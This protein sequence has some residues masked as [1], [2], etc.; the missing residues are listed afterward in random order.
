MKVSQKTILGVD[1]DTATATEETNAIIYKLQETARANVAQLGRDKNSFPL[2]PSSALKSDLDL[3][4]ALLNWEAPGTIPTN[5]I[6]G[7]AC[8]LLALGHVIEKHLV[9]HLEA[10]YKIPYKAQKITYGTI[11][12]NCGGD[13]ITL[14]GELDFVLDINGELIICDSKSSA[15]YPFKGDLPK[16]EHVAQINLY[17]H[18]QWARDLK[19]TRAMVFY[20]NKNDSNIKIAQ[21]EYNKQLAE[22]TL[23]RFQ[24]VFW[25]F[26]VRGQPLPVHVLGVDWQAKYSSFRD[27]IWAAY[28][29]PR[30]ARETVV[31]S[32]NTWARLPRAKKERLKWVVDNH[33]T[34]VLTNFKGG[35]IWAQKSGDDMSLEEIDGD[36]FSS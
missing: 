22:A 19:I 12:S 1:I 9:D 8:M 28:E 6:E 11:T 32:E 7:R 24:R 17:L 34:A 26:E 18:S 30:E 14:G 4:L 27:Y 2:R 36:G 31:L 13:T 15:D 23:A 10:A 33:G 20:Y 29:A 16:E 3:Y 21:F 35:Y 5:D 25:D